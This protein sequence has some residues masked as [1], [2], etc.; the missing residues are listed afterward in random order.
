MMIKRLCIEGECLGAALFAINSFCLADDLTKKTALH[1]PG[2]QP[3]VHCHSHAS[4]NYWLY[5]DKGN[6]LLIT[7]QRAVGIYML[8][9]CQLPL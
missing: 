5:A 2:F 7:K 4:V 9:L 8:P 3:I 6:W 1:L